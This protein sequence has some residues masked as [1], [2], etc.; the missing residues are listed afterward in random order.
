MLEAVYY[1]G[2]AKSFRTRDADNIIQHDET[3]FQLFAQMGPP[4][5]SRIGLERSTKKINV[6]KTASRSEHFRC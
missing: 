2:R 5:P 3:S 1:L 6:Q 4:T